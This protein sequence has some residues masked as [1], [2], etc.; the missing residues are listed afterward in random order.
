MYIELPYAGAAKDDIVRTCQETW[1]EAAT[2][3]GIDLTGFNPESALSER[4]SWARSQGLEIGAILSRYSSKLQHS[5]GGQ[6]TDCAEF[7]AWHKIYVPSEFVCV[8]EAVSGRKSRRDGLDRMKLILKHRLAGVLLVLKVSRLFRAAYKGYQFFQEEVVEEGLRGISVSQGIDTSEDKTWKALCVMHGLMD[9]MLLETIADH[10][11]S[12]LKNIFRLGFCVGALTNGYVKVEVPGARPTNLGLPR[13][14]PS[15]DPRF[16]ELFRQHCQLHLGGMSIKEGWRRWVQVGG[17]CDRRS[18]TGR[19][20]YSAYRRMLSNLRYTGRWAFGRKRNRWNSKRDYTVQDIQ[21]DTEV[22]FIQCEELRAIDDEPFFALQKCLERLKTGPR[23]P[24]RRKEIQ[25]WDLVTDVFVCSKCDV[26]FYQ[27]GANGRGMACKH[28]ELCPCKTT[29]RRKEAVQAVCHAVC[30][31]MQR[32]SELIE[33]VLAS[34]RRID[35]GGDDA[36]RSE[37]A[38]IEK[39]ITGQSNRIDDLSELAGQGTV[40]DRQ[41]LKAKI[42][43][44]QTERAELRLR[45][46]ELQR[47][48]A[49]ENA[50]I[51]PDRVREILADL[52]QLL[53]HA[54]AGKLG[55]DVVYRAAAV[56]RQLVGERILV[57]VERRA[58]RKR[59]NVLG[60]FRPEL[61][62]TTEGEAGAPRS[63]RD[64]ESAEVKVW[65][66]QPPKL[67]QLGQRVYQLMDVDGL[68]YRDA[69]TVLQSEGHKLNSGIVWQARQRYYEMIGQP[70][71]KRPYKTGRRRREDRRSA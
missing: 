1:V 30:E 29:V 45:E 49:H 32:D 16:A 22:V 31:L 64:V 10:V 27:S 26:R 53:E 7:A 61:I 44:A 47:Q 52:P 56:F 4:K 2:K 67:D 50:T 54:A 17:P 42:H 70:M 48:L 28:G 69:A 65:L 13:T 68:S 59:T 33:D 63:G 23:G 66:R 36:A 37:L 41:K 8:D 21:P 71:P 6:V 58:A 35:A 38:G 34:A 9:E 15:L 40:E 20:S 39:K 24:K 19:I 25:L 14:M 51:T 57:Y 62:R 55:Q 12:G 60:I 46:A 3:A 18:P 11:R 43:A 5:T